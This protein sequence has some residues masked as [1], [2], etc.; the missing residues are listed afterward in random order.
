MDTKTATVK[1]LFTFEK[2]A[3]SIT[4]LYKFHTTSAEIGMLISEFSRPPFNKLLPNLNALYA[5]LDYL[6]NE[7]IS[8]VIMNIILFDILIN[9]QIS[10]I[11]STR[12]R[13]AGVKCGQILAFYSVMISTKKNQLTPYSTP[14]VKLAIDPSRSSEF[15]SIILSSRGM[16]ICMYY[17]S[18]N[19]QYLISM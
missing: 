19:D 2:V 16:F 4:N 3:I 5:E 12:A 8:V 10:R 18:N 1:D 14:V 6:A 7:V 17:I 11:V 9:F 15:W 13:Y